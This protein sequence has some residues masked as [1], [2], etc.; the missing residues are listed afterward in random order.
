MT[1]KNLDSFILFISIFLLFQAPFNTITFDIT[2][3]DGA[4]GNFNIDPTTGVISLVSNIFPLTTT[5]YKVRI[6][7]KLSTL[8]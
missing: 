5:E 1:T 6:L 7:I 3:D 8:K 2:G 4:G